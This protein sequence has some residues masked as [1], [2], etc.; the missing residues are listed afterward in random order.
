MHL[1]GPIVIDYKQF[2]F[3]TQFKKVLAKAFATQ[4]NYRTNEKDRK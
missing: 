4:F 2:I 1:R 3:Y